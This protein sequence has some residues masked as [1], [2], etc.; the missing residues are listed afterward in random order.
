[1]DGGSTTYRIMIEG[2]GLGEG[3][4]GAAAAETQAFRRRTG[5]AAD[6]AAN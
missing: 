1:M 4:G 2:K 6:F 5:F 3:P